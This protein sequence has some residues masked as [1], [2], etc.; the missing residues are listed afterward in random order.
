[1]KHHIPAVLAGAA[2]FLVISCAG[3]DP[4][5]RYPNMVANVDPISAGAIEAAFDRMFSSA[6][7]VAEVEVIF[8]P[9]LNSVALQFRHELLRYRQFWDEAARRQFLASLE[10]YKADFAARN[11]DTRF[12]RT[13]SAYG[14]AKGYLEWET[15]RITT[16][17]IAYPTI[18]VGYRFKGESPFF[19]TLMRSAREV[20]VSGG[21]PNSESKEII[22]YFTRTQADELVRLFDQAYLLGLL[23]NRGSARSE[24]SPV[25]DEYHEPVSD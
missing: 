15:F 22:M 18:E 14:K 23:G 8:Y 1:M 11:L 7:R 12:R 3:V 21:N 24:E 4:E 6:L 16:T 5:T 20:E 2:L 13:R 10:S 9:R 25:F 19:T 17:R